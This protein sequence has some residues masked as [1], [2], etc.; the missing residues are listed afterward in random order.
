MG[1]MIIT[2]NGFVQ[3]KVWS[4][5]PAVTNTNDDEFVRR[6]VQVVL[7]VPSVVLNETEVVVADLMVTSESRLVAN[8]VPNDHNEI[9]DMADDRMRIFA[10]PENEQI[11]FTLV[12]NGH[13]VG[14]F[15]INY[16]VVA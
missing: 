16:G 3:T 5:R 13:F 9:S 10:I 2:R 1:T 12:G 15:T 11:R 6:D 14:P 7:D 8:L 4:S